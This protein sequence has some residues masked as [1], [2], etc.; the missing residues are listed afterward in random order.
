MLDSFSKDITPDQRKSDLVDNNKPLVFLK[1]WLTTAARKRYWCWH[2]CIELLT[3][4]PIPMTLSCG[5]NRLGFKNPED[6]HCVP[7]AERTNSNNNSTQLLQ[8]CC[9]VSTHP[10]IQLSRHTAHATLTKVCC[11]AQHICDSSIPCSGHYT[12]QQ[13]ARMQNH[14]LVTHLFPG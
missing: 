4:A 13:Q 14:A 1:V 3:E 6:C 2:F 7:D 9:Q 5:C 12:L 8:S 11:L 10:I